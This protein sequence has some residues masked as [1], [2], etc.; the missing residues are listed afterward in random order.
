MPCERM[1]FWVAL[2]LCPASF[3]LSIAS[4]RTVS[5]SAMRGVYGRAAVCDHPVPGAWPEEALGR[6]RWERSQAVGKSSPQK[7]SSILADSE[8]QKLEVTSSSNPLASGGTE[9]T[10]CTVLLSPGLT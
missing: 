7:P 2:I 8:A 5:S 6:E 9:Y 10:V 4:S 3:R 1:R